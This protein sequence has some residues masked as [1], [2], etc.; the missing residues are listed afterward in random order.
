LFEAT[1][2][3]VNPVGALYAL[4]AAEAVEKSIEKKQAVNL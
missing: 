1:C 3:S 4:K 2:K